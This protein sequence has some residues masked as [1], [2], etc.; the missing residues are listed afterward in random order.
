MKDLVILN[1]G[2]TRRSFEKSI[3]TM[4]ILVTGTAGFIGM[5]VACALHKAGH[6][7]VGLD[8]INTYYDT[9]LKYARLEVQGIRQAG[10]YYNKPIN[11]S[12]G[13]RFI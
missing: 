2:L 9:R 4:K 10:I 3:R 11:G 5:H 6:E 7:V 12:R 1:M 8:N 13:I